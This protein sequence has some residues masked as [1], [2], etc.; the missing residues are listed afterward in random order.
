MKK[1]RLTPLL[2]LA[3]VLWLVAPAFAAEP[4]SAEALQA[5]MLRSMQAKN[6][7]GLDRLKQSELQ[8]A[9]SRPRTESLDSEHFTALR[10]KRAAAVRL[11]E[12]GQFLG[13]W[14]RGEAIAQ[15]GR[16]LQYTDDPA[17][18]NGGNC[19]ACHQLD[20]AEVAY[21]NIGLSLTNYGARG[22]SPAVLEYTWT[23]IWDPHV[24]MPCSHMPRFGAQGILTMDQLRDVMAYL[25]DPESPVNASP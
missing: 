24:F 5:V 6:Q 4:L 18:P 25:L 3:G 13:D 9:C 1:R 8:Q 16:G 12:D 14:R 11:P 21:G 23:K 2:C 15:S 20:P 10:E 22:R 17:L 19:Y 7:A